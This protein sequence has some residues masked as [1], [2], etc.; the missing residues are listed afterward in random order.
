MHALKKPRLKHDG[1]ESGAELIV[2]DA[3]CEHSGI[4]DENGSGLSCEFAQNRVLLLEELQAPLSGELSSL[5]G[6]PEIR[7]PEHVVDFRAFNQVVELDPVGG[8]H[9]SIM[10]AGRQCY[11][12]AAFHQMLAQPEIGIYVAVGSK[13]RKDC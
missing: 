3:G 11:P 6:M 12:M 1:C 9:L 2:D 8:R 5:Q 10:W 7:V 4:G 13:G